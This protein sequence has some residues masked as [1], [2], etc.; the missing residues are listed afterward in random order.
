LETLETRKMTASAVLGFDIGSSLLI[1]LAVLKRKFTD[2]ASMTAS[3][4]RL[5]S[6]AS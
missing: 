5:A 6:L 1:H 4:T 2:L 3:T